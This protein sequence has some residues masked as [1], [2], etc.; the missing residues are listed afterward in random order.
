MIGT[1]N[2]WRFFTFLFTTEN[3][4]HTPQR[5]SSHLFRNV[6]FSWFGDHKTG[7]GNNSRAGIQKA[8]CVWSRFGGLCE[9]SSSIFKTLPNLHSVNFQ[10]KLSEWLGNI[11]LP[12]HVGISQLTQPRCKPNTNLNTGNRTRDHSPTNST[13]GWNTSWKIKLAIAF[14]KLTNN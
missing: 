7:Y 6:P 14:K 4:S 8:I 9:V 1:T 2:R 11:T 12:S 5:C 10:F 13:H 3:T